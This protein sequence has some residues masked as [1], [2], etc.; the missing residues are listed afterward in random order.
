MLGEEDLGDLH[1]LPRLPAL[2]GLHGEG[3]ITV[4][5]AG[6]L[7]ADLG[8]LVNALARLGVGDTAPAGGDQDGHSVDVSPATAGGVKHSAALP[9]VTTNN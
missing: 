3:G 8:V 6:V 7:H 1:E 9:T 2:P 5:R 4:H